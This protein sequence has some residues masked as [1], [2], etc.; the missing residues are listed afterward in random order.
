MPDMKDIAPEMSA[1]RVPPAGLRGPDAWSPPRIWPASIGRLDVGALRHRNEASRF[2]LALFSSSVVASFAIFVLVSL[3]QATKLLYLLLAIGAAIFVVWLF[4]QLRRIR[5]LADGVRVSAATLPEVQDAVDTVRERLGYHRRVDIFVVDKLPSP[6][7]ITLT[8]FFGI[9]VILAEGDALG[10]LSNEKDRQR[11]VFVLATYFGALKARHTQWSPLLVALQFTGLTKLVFPFIYSW[12]RATVYTGD[13][14]AYSCCGDLNVSLQAVYRLLVG[15]QVAPHLQPAGVVGQ[16]LAVRR[17]PILRLAQLLRPVP[18]AT[19]RYLELLAFASGREPTSFSTLRT[20]FGRRA[21][22]VD[23]VLARLRHAPRRGALSAPVGIVASAL[24]LVAGLVAGLT[25]QNSDLARALAA[26]FGSPSDT[27]A[28]EP[29]L[30]PPVPVS[31][32]MVAL[33]NRVPA[34]IRDTCKGAVPDR[35]SGVI[36]AIDC[37]ATAVSGPVHVSYYAFAGQAQMQASVETLIGALPQGEC[38][39]GNARTTWTHDGVTRGVLACYTSQSGAI[40]VLWSDDSAIVLS[41]AQDSALPVDQLLAWWET[42]AV[43]SGG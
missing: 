13:R 32:D 2:A 35:Q 24:L 26:A 8:S 27:P 18:H 7:P 6:P 34:D 23:D 21:V 1:A 9:H 28:P 19:N 20:L 43:L 14:I 3:G 39:T 29:P 36:T 15:K 38:S 25:A 17:K 30:P 41:L 12:Y 37:S 40:S 10:D 31:S 4:L 5:L 22:E 16:A 42:H 33:V 11:L